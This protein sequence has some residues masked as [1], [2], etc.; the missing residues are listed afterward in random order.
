MILKNQSKN[1]KGLVKHTSIP[2]LCSVSISY[3]FHGNTCQVAQL[4]KT[5]TLTSKRICLD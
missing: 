3:I 4:P 2:H 5:Y 1:R